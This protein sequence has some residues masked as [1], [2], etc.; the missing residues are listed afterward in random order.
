MPPH[1]AVCRPPGPFRKRL[2][3]GSSKA[4][5]RRPTCHYVQVF[6]TSTRP[7]WGIFVAASCS[8]R[9]AHSFFP[10]G[11][12]L[13]FIYETNLAFVGWTPFGQ[14]YAFIFSWILFAIILYHFTFMFL[15]YIAF[16]NHNRKSG[17]TTDKVRNHWKVLNRV[18]GDLI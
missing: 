12:I 11:I 6:N 15:C 17:F 14:D 16:V 8:F 13:I 1:N 5:W 18:I 10:F 4:L 3:V 7:P 9:A 2:D